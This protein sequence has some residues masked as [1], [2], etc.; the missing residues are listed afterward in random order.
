MKIRKTIITLLIVVLSIWSLST[1][2]FA[3]QTGFTTQEVSTEKRENI[4][5]NIDLKITMQEAK[6]LGISCFDVSDN[7]TIAI[8]AS[9]AVQRYV[10]VYD[11][12]GIFQYGYVFKSN[13][14]F[15]IEWDNE[16]IIIHFIRSNLAASFD[17]DGN[18]IELRYFDDTSEYYSYWDQL[19]S[20]ERIVNGTSYTIENNIGLLKFLTT[21]RSQLIKT[22]ANGDVTILYDVKTGHIARAITLIVFI[23]VI[24]I[25]AILCIKP[26]FVINN[27]NK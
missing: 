5:S 2:I 12:Y 19:G 27:Q 17:K 20:S 1:S 3:M 10:Y 24:F 4:L 8:G 11:K 15:R 14:S 23:I 9:D 7:E 6:D 22:E 18:N 16:N 21:S 26:Y 25:V 13:G